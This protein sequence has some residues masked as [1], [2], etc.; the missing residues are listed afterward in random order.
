M[1][2]RSPNSVRWTLATVN[3]AVITT[4]GLENSQPQTHKQPQDP[5]K[6]LPDNPSNRWSCPVFISQSHNR[7][8][9]TRE[10]ASGVKISI[11]DP[12][13]A[14]LLLTSNTVQVSDSNGLL[15]GWLNVGLLSKYTRCIQHAR[16]HSV[17]R[18]LK[19]LILIPN[20]L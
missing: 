13:G 8:W 7:D 4:K 19:I 1:S 5:Q 15:S 18:I 12:K 10:K 14:L 20:I 9:A 17:N 6:E 16:H 3:D 2:F 11:Q